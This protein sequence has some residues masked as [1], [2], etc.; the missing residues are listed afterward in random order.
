MFG[1]LLDAICESQLTIGNQM[2]TNA[3]SAENISETLVDVST[4]WAGTTPAGW[5]PNGPDMPG[6]APPPCDPQHVPYT[7][8]DDHNYTPLPTNFNYTVADIQYAVSYLAGQEQEA[9]G[10]HLTQLQAAS[11]AW[12]NEGQAMQNLADLQ[13]APLST[14]QQGESSQIQQDQ[15]SVS[16][17]AALG[18][19]IA[20]LDG[21][22]ASIITLIA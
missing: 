2:A 14:M 15:S 13:K 9:S 22:T 4:A 6:H 3:Q 5:N 10:D 8:A 12:T 11:S 7:Q 18:N 20:D 19:G 21:T 16:A 17:S 1:G